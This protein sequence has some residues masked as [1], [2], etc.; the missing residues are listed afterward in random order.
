MR[1]LLSQRGVR[2]LADNG[3]IYVKDRQ[4]ESHSTWRCERNKRVN[5]RCDG[6][7]KLGHDQVTITKEHNHLPDHAYVDAECAKVTVI[8]SKHLKAS[9]FAGP[10]VRAR[11][12]NNESCI[13]A[14]VGEQRGQ[15]TLGRGK[16]TIGVAEQHGGRCST[17]TTCCAATMRRPDFDGKNR[18]SGTQSP[19]C[20]S[21]NMLRHDSAELAEQS[22]TDALVVTTDAAAT[23]RKRKKQRTLDENMA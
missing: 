4:Y 21:R 2:K 15:P 12:R 14:Y 19:S 22:R 11:P 23:T 10:I 1:W 18:T 20:S 8:L 6:R 5:E 7:A 17:S 16:R 13:G 9:C 3:F